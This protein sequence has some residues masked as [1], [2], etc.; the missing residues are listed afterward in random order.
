MKLKRCA[1]AVALAAFA[2]TFLLHP[3]RYVNACFEGIA[4]WAECV[5]PSLFP[6]MVVTLIAVK[7]GLAEGCARPFAR[8][9]DKLKLPPVGAA[10]FL[11]SICSGYPAGSR[12]LCEYYEHGEL[13]QGQARRLSA[14]CS[15]SGPLF[16]VGSVGFKMLGNRQAGF[17]LLCAHLASV[18]AVGVIYCLLGKEEKT[19]PAP[20]SAPKGNVL[21]DAFSSAVTSVLIAGGFICFFYT[22]SAMI[23]DLNLLLPLQYALSIPFRESNA[24]AVCKGL[25]EATGGCCMLAASADQWTLP[26][27]GFLVTFGGA[28][29]LCQQ[30]CYLAKCGVHAATFCFIKFLQGA[31]CFLL[32]SI[33]T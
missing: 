29:I 8:V 6:F 22:A 19:T 10:I 27:T 3:E 14:L 1:L 32:L 2:A 15:T 31:L 26:L 23:C 24:A 18:A 33:A 5:L 4:L 21:Y 11:I 12:I 16:I 25:V 13:T 7:S 28:S 17:Y 20:L 9:T 30:L